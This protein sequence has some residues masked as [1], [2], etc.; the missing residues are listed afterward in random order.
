MRL[1]DQSYFATGG[2]CQHFFEPLDV[3][4]L[5]DGLSW[6][7]Q[8]KIPYWV[9]GAGSNSLVCDEFWPGAVVSLSKFTWFWEL[10]ENRFFIGAGM[11][12]S[13]VVRKLALAGYSGLE[14]MN[15][16]PGLIGGTA[17]M[18]ARCYGG[19]IS[20]VTQKVHVVTKKGE[21]QVLSGKDVFFGYKDTK[22]MHRGD[23]V[24]GIEVELKPGWNSKHQE[25][26]DFC[27]S[28]R[29]SK[30]Q[31]IWPTCGCVFKNNYDPS[32][33]VSSGML[34]ELAGCKGMRVGKA[35]VSSK[36]A[37]FIFNR[38]ASSNEILDLSFKMQDRVWEEFGVWLHYEME[39]LGKPDP[40]GQS[41]F[42]LRK[43]GL[44]TQTQQSKLKDARA[45]FQAKLAGSASPAL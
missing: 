15:G 43:Q 14:W 6:F 31:F 28:D 22:M 37:N 11:E 23:L 3:G 39:L 21:V 7:N 27:L 17:R 32:V 38:G 20:Q 33:S 41:R 42:L 44:P 26:A 19:E 24:T 34:L 40:S 29:K 10:D 45:L 8:L 9:L 18:N 36:H 16:L 2:S 13:E 12:N 5:A 25:K 4:E 1:R 35:E 30:D